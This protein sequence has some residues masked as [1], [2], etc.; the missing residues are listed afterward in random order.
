MTGLSIVMTAGIPCGLC[1]GNTVVRPMPESI[2]DALEIGSSIVRVCEHCL[3]VEPSPGT[4]ITRNWEP[5]DV[6]EALPKDPEAAVATAVL[7]T[8]LS[9]LALNREEIQ[10][11]VEYLET[12]Q[13]VDPLLALDRISTVPEFDP[14]IDPKRR[15]AQLAQLLNR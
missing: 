12:E 4:Q 5:A 6:S 14:P 15:R 3:T 10:S 13:G 7:L 1:E 2:T 8:L 9:S 11:V